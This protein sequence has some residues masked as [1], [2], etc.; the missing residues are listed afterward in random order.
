[1]FM[2]SWGSCAPVCLLLTAPLICSDSSKDIGDRSRLTAGE[3]LH[4]K[5]EWR[6]VTAGKGRLSLKR[7]PGGAGWQTNLQVESTGLVSK[8]YK[9]QDQ[10]SALLNADL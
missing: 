7:G 4:Y 1:M 6:L 3:T 5:I 2:A 9:I 8:L 10:Y